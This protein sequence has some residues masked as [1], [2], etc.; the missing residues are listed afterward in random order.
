[1][2][3]A[4]KITVDKK[5]LFKGT[6]AADLQD[7]ISECIE[8]IDEIRYLRTQLVETLWA[9]YHWMRHVITWE[10]DCEKSPFGWC[11]YNHREDRA[12]DDCVFCHQPEERK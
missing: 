12:H 6:L 2:A 4:I 1:M 9:D 11:A 10:W 7:S 5:E 3:K 8:K